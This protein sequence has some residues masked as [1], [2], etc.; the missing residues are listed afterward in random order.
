MIREVSG[1]IL[2]TDAEM[3]A[4]GVAPNDHMDHGLALELRKRWPAMH[5]DFRHYHKSTH[6]KP[7]ELWFWGG[8][9]GTR[10]ANLFTQEESKTKGGRPGEASVS[11]VRHCL[12]ELRKLVEEEGV[13]SVALPKLATG[14]GR[15]DWDDVRPLI[16][17]H[18]GDLDADVIVYTEYHAG[19]KAK[20]GL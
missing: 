2:L 20:E 8:A 9:G 17:E 14:V 1:D 4:Q 18:L 19:Q 10:I 7:G 12:K 5:K 15:L 3:T 11:N 13:K 16:E 6:P